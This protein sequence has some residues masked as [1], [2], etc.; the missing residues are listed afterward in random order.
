[1]ID[2]PIFSSAQ[3]GAWEPGVRGEDLYYA[4]GRTDGGRY[5]FV[6][7]IYKRTREALIISARDMDRKERKYYGKA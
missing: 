7:F 1:M 4:Y 5:V 2:D 6:V 3:A